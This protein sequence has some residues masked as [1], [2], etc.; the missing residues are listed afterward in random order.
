MKTLSYVLK[1]LG[2]VLGSMTLVRKNIHEALL[3]LLWP[4]RIEPCMSE[5]LRK[6]LEN[7]ENREKIVSAIHRGEKSVAT[8]DGV[9]HIN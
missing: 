3:I 1:C 6:T 5:G 4:W 2:L 7:P 9:Y 8:T